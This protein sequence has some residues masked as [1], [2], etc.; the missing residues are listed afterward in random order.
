MKL[1]VDNLNVTLKVQLVMLCF[2]KAYLYNLLCVLVSFTFLTPSKLGV[3]A[4]EVT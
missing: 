1:I 3:V 2:K 4:F